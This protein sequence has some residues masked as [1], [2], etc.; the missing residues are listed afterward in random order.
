MAK[1]IGDPLSDLPQPS[2]SAD[3]VASVSCAATAKDR[4]K[5]LF[6]QNTWSDAILLVGREEASARLIPVHTAIVATASPTLA[7]MLG[8]NWN[9]DKA[10]VRI[11]DFTATVLLSVLRWIYTE[12]LVYLQEDWSSI[13]EFAIQYLMDPLV[14]AVVDSTVMAVNTFWDTLSVGVKLDCRL[15]LDKCHT[16]M[17]PQ[18]EALLNQPVF[19]KQS[20]AVVTA[21]TLMD[22]LN[23]CEYDLF[24][25]CVEWA[26]QV[27][28]DNELDGD[29]DSYSPD[30]V[31]EVM[32]PFMDNINFKSMTIVELAHFRGNNGFLSDAELLQVYRSQGRSHIIPPF[33]TKVR[34]RSK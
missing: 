4:N 2:A 27:C 3:A 8:D 7:A 14:T 34:S 29:V 9:Q 18:A 31:R 28:S 5:S 13:L 12:E 15:L 6:N 17:A 23:I 24:C 32:E 11:R 19:L 22:P 33:S 26:Q 16:F 25:R 20:E 21:V 1:R 10:P 30:D